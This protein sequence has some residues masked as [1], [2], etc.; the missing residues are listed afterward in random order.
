LIALLSGEASRYVTEHA[1]PPRVSGIF[2]VIETQKGPSMRYCDSIFG[3]LLKVLPR[4][5]FERLVERHRGD[6]YAKSFSAWDHLVVM[7][8]GQL[9]GAFSLRSLEAGWNAHAHHHY[10]LGSGPVAR[11]TLADANARRAPAI[12]A[13]TFAWL[14][15]L[16]QRKLKSEAAEL[17][18]LIDASPIRLDQLFAWADW[19]GRTRGLK[20]HVVYNPK[21]DQPMRVEI[22][23]AT[24]NDVTV[25]RA[26]PIEPG[27]TYVFDKAYVDYGW[28]TRLDAAGCRFV[29]RPK[30]NVRFTTLAK[31]K[32]ADAVGDSFVVTEDEIVQLATQ[33]RGK[34]TFPLRRLTVDIQG[35]RKLTI[36][37]NDL[38]APAKEIAGLYKQ[39]WQIELLFR[40]I[41][42]H[43]RIKTFLGRSENAVRLQIIS[44]MIAFLLL[45]IAAHHSRCKLS[46]IRFAGLAR[47]CLF[48]RKP[49]DRLDKPPD[50]PPTYQPHPDQL[51]LDYAS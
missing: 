33:G 45:R 5:V 39:R 9:S 43:L 48:T 19:N 28:W 50:C 13:E 20:L 42:Q 11:S 15:G 37:C 29:T 22:T 49:L 4:G 6:R 16:A 47:L 31:L 46:P 23:P 21:S 38:D 14:S 12:F 24:V 34:L 17:V 36:I 27:A 30:T 2:L 18:R 8:Y 51:V 7:I 1:R 10:H 41:K 32:L 44:A 25:G 3:G 26:V 40:W 35:G